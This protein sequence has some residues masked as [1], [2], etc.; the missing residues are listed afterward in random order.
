MAFTFNQP[1]LFDRCQKPFGSSVVKN[2]GRGGGG[3][4]QLD[5][6]RMA[7]I[8]PD[9]EAVLA[10]RKSLLVVPDDDILKLLEREFKPPPAR[11]FDQLQR[12]RPAGP[13][14]ADASTQG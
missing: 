3:V 9:P 8:G 4:S 14:Q 7:L 6:D 11:R 13:V 12:R 1:L 2:F 5:L 10:E